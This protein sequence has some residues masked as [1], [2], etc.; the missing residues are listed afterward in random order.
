MKKTIVSLCAFALAANTFAQLTAGAKVGLNYTTWS[1]KYETDPDPKPDNP[2]G[3]GFHLG[4]YLQFDLSDQIGLRPELLFSSR[5]LKSSSTETTTTTV[6]GVTTT[7]KTESDNKLHYSYLEIPVLL[8]WKANDMI[9]L[10]FGPALGLMMGAKTTSD[11]TITTTTGGSTTTTS[12]SSDV[13]GSDAKKGLRGTEIGL[14]VGGA[15]ETEG[16]LNFGLR[17]WRGLTTVNED[18]TD[19]FKSYTNLIQVSVG[20]SFLKP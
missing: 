15:Y 12:S 6:F 16:G 7:T 13:S 1:T 11:N 14:C 18:F 3:I 19:F 9:A 8:A 2:N 5:G 20:Y 10:H 4:G 17:Y